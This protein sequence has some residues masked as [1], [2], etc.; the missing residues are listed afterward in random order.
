ML[1]QARALQWLLTTLGASASLTSAAPGGVHDTLAPVGTATPYVIVQKQTPNGTDL[2]AG[3]ARRVMNR[4]LWVVKAVGKTNEEYA[5][6]ITAADAIDTALDRKTGTTS[7]GR[8]L[9]CVRQNDLQYTELRPDGVLI[10][11]LG[12]QYTIWAQPLA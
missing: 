1:E 2:I 3:G 7:D 5:A 9:A 4:S 8:V 11:H 6:L 10:S 12:G